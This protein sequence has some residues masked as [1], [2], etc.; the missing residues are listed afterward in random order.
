MFGVLDAAFDG[1]G[2]AE[3]AVQSLREGVAVGGVNLTDANDGDEQLAGL[4][5]LTPAFAIGFTLDGDA[6]E[7]GNVVFG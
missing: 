7:F 5:I 3:V 2:G 6:E 1:G 4:K